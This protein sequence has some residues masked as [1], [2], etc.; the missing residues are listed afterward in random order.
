VDSP[1]KF[2]EDEIRKIAALKARKPLTTPSPN[3]FHFDPTQPLRQIRSV[4]AAVTR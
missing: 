3:D 4:N 2:G 1:Q